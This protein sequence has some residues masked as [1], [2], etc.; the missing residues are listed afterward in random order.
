MPTK[1]I[2]LPQKSLK[3]NRVTAGTIAKTASKIPRKLAGRQVYLC[4]RGLSVKN[5]SMKNLKSSL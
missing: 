3:S 2:Y 5:I 1:Q 4:L